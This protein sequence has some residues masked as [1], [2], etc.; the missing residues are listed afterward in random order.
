M[1]IKYCLLMLL[2]ATLTLMPSSCS[3]INED[4]SDCGVDNTIDYRL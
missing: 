1:R 4:L 2:A 3:I